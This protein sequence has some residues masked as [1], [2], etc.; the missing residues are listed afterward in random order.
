MSLLDAMRKPIIGTTDTVRLTTDLGG[1]EFGP[2]FL[3]EKILLP[4]RTR[5]K[6]SFGRWHGRLNKLQSTE[7]MLETAETI[8]LPTR[9]SQPF[10]IS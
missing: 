10:Y 8:W 1:P 4:A 6:L 7:D 2:G 5:R 3:V 9:S